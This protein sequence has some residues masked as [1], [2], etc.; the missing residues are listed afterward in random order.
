MDFAPEDVITVDMSWDNGGVLPETY[1][2]NITRRQLGELLMQ[3]DDMAWDT[4]AADQ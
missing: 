4:E 3:I 1:S 2:R